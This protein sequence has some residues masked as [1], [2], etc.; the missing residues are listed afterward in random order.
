MSFISPAVCGISD[1]H[2]IWQEFS[3]C[4]FLCLFVFAADGWN[5][6]FRKNST[7]QVI[8]IHTQHHNLSVGFYK[9]SHL[10]RLS[11]SLTSVAAGLLPGEWRYTRS[12]L[13]QLL[14]L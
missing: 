7:P 5:S 4:F 12:C 2:L 8:V 6:I 14:L 11:A 3:P 9:A 10:L 1:S 13:S